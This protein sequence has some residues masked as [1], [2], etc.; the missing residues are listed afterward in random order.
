MNRILIA[1]DEPKIAAFLKKGLEANGFIVEVAT[2][3]KLASDMAFSQEFDLMLLDL[4]LP[5]KDGFMLLEELRG[6]GLTLSIIILTARDDI[7]DK[8]AGLEGGA[9]DY[10]TKPFRF[11][12]LLA[13]I[14]L[15][16][17]NRVDNFILMQT[18]LK[19]GKIVL[20]LRS[21]QVYLDNQLVEVSNTEFN[22]LEILISHKGQVMTRQQL[23]DHVWGYSYDPGSNIVDVYI[24]YLRKKVG[25]N[26][27][28]TVRGI[29]YQWIG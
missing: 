19:S 5:L 3:A 17:K 25:K 7:K 12:E 28:A 2:D 27:I 21:R 16:L 1:E 18:E 10:V 15:R 6:Q 24:G 26:T 29:G 8:V 9:D 22:L 14:R 20:N 4:G 13:R 11:E 23:L